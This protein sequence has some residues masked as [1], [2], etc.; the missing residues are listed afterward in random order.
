MENE[1]HKLKTQKVDIN[2]MKLLAAI[3]QM[4]M[5][6][7]ELAINGMRSAV[8]YHCLYSHYSISHKNLVQTECHGCIVLMNNPFH[9]F[10][11]YFLEMYIFH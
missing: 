3:L 2:F 8:G 6:L 4:G 7:G 5:S 10:V 1:E 11:Y 9:S